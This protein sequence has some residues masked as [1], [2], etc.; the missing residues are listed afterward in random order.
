MGFTPF[1]VDARKGLPMP[2][3]YFDLRDG[4][5][6]FDDH[7]GV[8]LV[9]IESAQVEA[10]E[11]LADSVKDLCSRESK[12]LGYSISVEVRNSEGLIFLLSFRFFNTS[13]GHG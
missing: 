7:E 13:A 3:Y 10:A 8:D 2:R 5:A 4:E 1:Y 9:D 12:P 11:F 6:F